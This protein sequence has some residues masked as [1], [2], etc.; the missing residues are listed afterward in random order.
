MKTRRVVAQAAAFAVD[1]PPVR[2]QVVRSRDVPVMEECRAGQSSAQP[3]SRSVAN[4][5]IAVSRDIHAPGFP[6]Y[7]A[8]RQR[9]VDHMQ[10][11]VGQIAPVLSAPPDRGYTASPR[12]VPFPCSC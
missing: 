7:A 2:S 10:R 1:G 11:L 8:A 12:P 3:E 4:S 9:H 6:E 5:S